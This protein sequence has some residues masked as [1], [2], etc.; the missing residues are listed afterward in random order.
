MGSA[1]K[2]YIP[3]KII[4]TIFQDE[5]SQDESSPKF[6]LV[7]DMQDEAR[8]T[9]S[10]IQDLPA[11]MERALPGIFPDASSPYVHSCGGG[12]TGVPEHSFREEV[13]RGTDLPHLM[14]HV[15]LH[16]LSRRMPACSAFCGQR[17][18]DL[19]NGITTHYYIVM[20]YPSKLGAVVA[21][22]LALEL[23]SA[24]VEGR[25][26]NIDATAVLTKVRGLLEPMLSV[27][28]PVL[29]A[30]EQNAGD[31]QIHLQA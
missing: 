5:H 30:V 26:V 17:S 11:K 2:R 16:L 25:T 21:A 1:V 20:D 7:L 27:P 19:E 22:E 14:E 15:L 31:V 3:L 24:W 12:T 8:L 28:A 10:H 29:S 4:R 9:T 18:I 13:E 23:V 6:V